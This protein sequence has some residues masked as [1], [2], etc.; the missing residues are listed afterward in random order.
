MDIIA[1]KHCSYAAR[2]MENSER[3]TTNP[4]MRESMPQ[5]GHVADPDHLPLSLLKATD[6]AGHLHQYVRVVD[7]RDGDRTL[8]IN[9]PVRPTVKVDLNAPADRFGQHPQIMQLEIISPH[10]TTGNTMMRIYIEFTV[11]DGRY[12]SSMVQKY[13]SHQQWGQFCNEAR[14]AG[15]RVRCYMH[16]C[17]MTANDRKELALHFPQEHLSAVYLP[18]GAIPYVVGTTQDRKAIASRILSRIE[19]TKIA[20][21]KLFTPVAPRYG[22]VLTPH[23]LNLQYF[24]HRF[25][26]TIKPYHQNLLR[27]AIAKDAKEAAQAACSLN[28]QNAP[29]SSGAHGDTINSTP[30][31]RPAG[32][33]DNAL[34]SVASRPAVM[35]QTSNVPLIGWIEPDIEAAYSLLQMANTKNETFTLKNPT[36]SAARSMSEHDMEIVDSAEDTVLDAAARKQLKRHNLGHQHIEQRKSVAE[37][38]SLVF[39]IDKGKFSRTGIAPQLEGRQDGGP[40]FRRHVFGDKRDELL[41]SYYKNTDFTKVLPADNRHRIQNTSEARDVDD[42]EGMSDDFGMDSDLTLPVQTAPRKSAKPLGLNRVLKFGKK[43]PQPLIVGPP[44][45]AALSQP[46]PFDMKPWSADLHKNFTNNPLVSQAFNITSL[47]QAQTAVL[48]RPTNGLATIPGASNRIHHYSQIASSPSSA[49]RRTRG[50]TRE[51]E[52]DLIAIMD[53]VVNKQGLTGEDAWVAAEEMMK[54]Q[55]YD[56][57]IGGIRM[58]WCRGLRSKTQIDERIRKNKKRIPKKSL[59]SPY[60]APAKRSTFHLNSNAGASIEERQFKRPEIAKRVSI[61]LIVKDANGNE[62]GATKSITNQQPGDAIK[63]KGKRLQDFSPAE[64]PRAKRV[65]RR[66]ANWRREQAKNDQEFN[67]AILLSKAVEKTPVS[68]NRER[69]M[70]A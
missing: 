31:L 52:G 16:G 33:A 56:R 20:D 67:D 38:S 51:E 49:M 63:G 4:V 7:P 5:K 64:N 50:W 9:V 34:Q 53:N 62:V 54:A 21:L 14:P 28:V 18:T 69:A 12:P 23:I 58:A 6:Q 27:A 70:S 45:G 57:N 1:E 10:A 48:S 17:S 29:Q 13:V 40:S 2:N 44:S 15:V 61:R 19:L 36:N 25:D 30:S 68:E 43:K 8:L 37:A 3:N 47:P 35:N 60:I 46:S 26:I 39:G 65:A 66:G 55:G 24:R 32:T 59:S 22:L 42:D 11:S 41:D